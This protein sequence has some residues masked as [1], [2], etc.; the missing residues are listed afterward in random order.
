LSPNTRGKI[1]GGYDFGGKP[2]QIGKA[3]NFNESTIRSTLKLEPVRDRNK[4]Q[5]RS[6]RPKTYS[7][8]DERHILRQVRL[9]PKCTYADVRRACLVKLCD[10]TIRSILKQY[11]ITNWRAKKRP[12]LTEE[13]AAIR[14]AS[15]IERLDWTVDDWKKY[16]WS[17][18]CSVE[19]G[20][21]KTTEWVFRTPPVTARTK[22]RVIRFV[23][24]TN[25][26][27]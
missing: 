2:S 5:P 17:D 26:R 18:E 25:R 23:D 11:G 7:D 20:K 13:H 15:C 6:G 24:C 22:C 8:R 19:R 3:Y 12:H 27:Y 21:G 1:I 9:H 10:N 14:L 4:S 16:M